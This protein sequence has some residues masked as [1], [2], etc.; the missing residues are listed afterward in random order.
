MDAIIGAIQKHI[1]VG[2][3]DDVYQE[4]NSMFD[5]DFIAVETL[6]NDCMGLKDVP[7]IIQHCD[8]NHIENI[9]I[10]ALDD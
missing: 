8:A 1:Q 5:T 2:L 10:Y 3:P 6:R 9:V 4:I 7:E